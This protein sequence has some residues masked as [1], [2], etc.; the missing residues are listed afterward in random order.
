MVT[1]WSNG[2]TA[3]FMY[4]L[5]RGMTDTTLT[6]HF[7]PHVVAFTLCSPTLASSTLRTRPSAIYL[8]Q[9][10]SRY[11]V[12]ESLL[13]QGEYRPIESPCCV[14][15]KHESVL[16]KRILLLSMIVCWRRYTSTADF[17]KITPSQMVCLTPSYPRRD[18]RVDKLSRE[19]LLCCL[20]P[21]TTRKSPGSP[22]SSGYCK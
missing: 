9:F 13:W 16:Q 22:C 7:T 8:W 1:G 19:S 20:G 4:A 5:L 17:T 18:S 2:N 6:I 10:E 14:R 15:A 3:A 12:W 11:R 21:K